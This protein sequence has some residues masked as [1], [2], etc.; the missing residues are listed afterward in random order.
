MSEISTS[1]AKISVVVNQIIRV[2]LLPNAL[3]DRLALQELLKAYQKLD[4]QLPVYFLN[5]F[6]ELNSADFDIKEDFESKERT[7]MKAAEAFVVKSLSNRIELNYNIQLTK[8]RY[9]TKVFLEEQEA[10]NWL[11]ELQAKEAK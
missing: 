2:E 8:K 1:I 4:L 3:V 10:L 9:P 6:Q 7:K 11:K 5:V